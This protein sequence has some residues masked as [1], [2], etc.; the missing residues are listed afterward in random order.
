[1]EILKINKHSAN[2]IIIKKNVWLVHE[3][4]FIVDFNN[5]NLQGDISGLNYLCSEGDALFNVDFKS[6]D[7][8]EPDDFGNYDY[9]YTM[10]ISINTNSQLY[11][12]RYQNNIY[13]EV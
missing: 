11:K 5:E 12:N 1:M 13:S 8:K 10:T 9:V 4:I 2:F 6:K 7:G 3:A